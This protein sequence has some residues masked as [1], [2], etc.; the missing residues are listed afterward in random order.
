M[1]KLIKGD[2]LPIFCGAASPR[3]PVSV[4]LNLDVGGYNR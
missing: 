1:S 2:I 4:G 3:E